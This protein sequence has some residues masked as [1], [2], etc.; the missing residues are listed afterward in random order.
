MNYLL[1]CIKFHYHTVPPDLFL[2]GCI[3]LIVEYD[4]EDPNK[5]TE[6]KKIIA[7]HGGEVEPSY[8]ARVTHLLCK[9]Q[10]HGLVMQVFIYHLIYQKKKFRI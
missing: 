5:V 10:R 3:F 9:T 1:K 8:C 4:E 2:L 6:W 7:K